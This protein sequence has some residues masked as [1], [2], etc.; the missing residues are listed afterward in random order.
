MQH[1]LRRKDRALSEAEARALLER[2]EYG[3]LSICCTGGEPYG[4]PLSYCVLENE[5][6]FHA[7]LEGRKLDIL[8]NNSRGSF[9][10]VGA[11]E[12][13]PAKFSTRYES[14]IVSGPVTEAFDADKQRGLEG[15][16]AK[17]SS[18]FMP[19]GLHYI[20][21]Q[22]P[23]TRVFKIYIETICGKARR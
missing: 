13:L 12:I 2:G 7:A 1:E 19:Q 22:S 17:Y 14:V 10:V 23:T 4:I 18:N 20:G 16:V 11:T 6:Y 5:I 9:C 8:V 15:L 21:V 3:V